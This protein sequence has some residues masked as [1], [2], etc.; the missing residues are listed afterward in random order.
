MQCND[1]PSMMDHPSWAE[2]GRTEAG[3][4]GGVGVDLRVTAALLRYTCRSAILSGILLA[5]RLGCM[6]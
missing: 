2:D 6:R 3:R 1:K 4:G 5:G